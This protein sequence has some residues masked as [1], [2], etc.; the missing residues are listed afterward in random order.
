M[1][2]NKLINSSFD[3]GLD[4]SDEEK[5]IIKNVAIESETH[6]RDSF[7]IS[8]RAR[9]TNGAHLFAARGESAPV[10]TFRTAA[11]AAGRARRGGGA[12]APSSA[13]RRPPSRSRTPATGREPRSVPAL[14]RVRECCALRPTRWDHVTRHK[15]RVPLRHGSSGD[16]RDGRRR[17]RQCSGGG[18]GRL[19]RGSRQPLQL[20]RLRLGQLREHT[21]VSPPA[22]RPSR[23]RDPA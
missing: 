21:E 6:V 3:G 15:D 22:A 18:G 7:Q 23:R 1:F 12:T 17:R 10:S 2:R 8:N 5:K 20:P 9:I 16:E 11:A 14:A 19:R 4:L 13:S